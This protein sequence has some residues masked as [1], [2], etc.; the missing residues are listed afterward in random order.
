[1]TTSDVTTLS[2]LERRH[3]VETVQEVL[4]EDGA[5]AGGILPWEFLDDLRE[6]LRILGADEVDSDEE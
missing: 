4:L 1:M 3:I 5:A 6:I 2:V